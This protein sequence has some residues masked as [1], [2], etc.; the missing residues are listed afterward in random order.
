MFQA[1][2]EI[3]LLS[4]QNMHLIRAMA[5]TLDLNPRYK[6]SSDFSFRDEPSETNAS[7]VAAVG[8]THYLSGKGANAYETPESYSRHGIFLF[9]TDA[10]EF[11][12]SQLRPF[13]ASHR[14]GLSMVDLW[15]HLGTAWMKET[16][17]IWKKE[18]RKSLS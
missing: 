12:D 2:Q 6:L 3:E 7:L 5:A 15:M 10:A 4:H 8:G 13:Q 18:I 9:P 17:E 16:V 14:A 11:L 1:L